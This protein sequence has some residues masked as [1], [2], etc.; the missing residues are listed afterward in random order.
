M[1][2]S[3]P[4][5]IF[6]SYFAVIGFALYLFFDVIIG[7]IKPLVRQAMED[8]LADA[9]NLLAEMVAPA[10]A[11]G[12]IS[13]PEFR[14]QILHYNERNLKA[15]IWST[16]KR[17]ATL[18]FYV[19]DVQGTV[20]FDSQ[21]QRE[22][23]DFS[24][25][26]DV[27]LTLRGRYGV[28]S[29]LA[30]S[31]DPTSTV[32]YVAAPVYADQSLIG[33]LTV[34]KPNTTVE[35]FIALTRQKTWEKGAIVLLFAVFC[36]AVLAYWFTRS[37]ELLVSYTQKV[38]QGKR[39]SPPEVKGK[40]LQLLADS[41]E[42]MRQQLEG[43]HYVESYVQSLT[44]ELKSPLA[45][46]AASAELLEQPLP[47]D[48]QQRFAA[49]IQGESRRVE[50]LIEQLL[51]LAA[52]EKKQVLDDIESIELCS[53][54]ESLIQAKSAECSQQG[55]KVLLDCA[56]GAAIDANRLLVVQA[57]DNLLSNAIRFSPASGL[58]NIKVIEDNHRVS[59]K[60]SDQGAGI[61]DFA[62][63]R[64]FER[65]YSLPVEGSSEKSSGL[66]L[67]FVQE[68][69]A[70]HGGEIQLENSASGVSA[71]LV[72]PHGSTGVR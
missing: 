9:A 56:E 31:D 61:P 4:A 35:P 23:Q 15:M 2:L 43:K 3:F 14:Q 6:L 69:M 54:L 57:V 39:I 40:E 36:G 24:Q 52:L 11:D 51:S 53:L 49:I 42:S 66:G 13:T 22:G 64:V 38:A 19:T 26:N 25:W 20:V 63:P 71:T 58:I 70:L 72:F 45:G 46:I 33:V 62:M 18:S 8:S 41:V 44:H 68:I 30:D 48:Q 16:P 28:R 1:N 47:I 10:L 27:Y 29:S 32:M 17:K 55:V 50:K 60:V 34:F 5:R 7:E 21:Q 59:I 37:V 12:R 65:F 67:S